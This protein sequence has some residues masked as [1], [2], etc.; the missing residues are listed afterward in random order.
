MKKKLLSLF[1][2]LLLASCRYENT[3]SVEITGRAAGTVSTTGGG[4]TFDPG[5]KNLLGAGTLDVTL[6]NTYTTAV[7][8]TN[9]LADPNATSPDSLTA[10]KAWRAE[11]VKLRLNPA[12]FTGDNSPSPALLAVSGENVLPLDG[13]VTAPNGGKTVEYMDVLS[14]AL[15]QQVAAAADPTA[16]RRVVFGVTLRGRTLDGAQLDSGEWFFPVDVCV[17]CLRPAVACVTGQDFVA[18]NCFGFGQDTTP[19]CV[20]VDS[21]KTAC[22]SACVDVKTDPSNCGSCGTVCTAGQTCAAGT[23]K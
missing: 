9:N 12:S 4:C 1:G 2:L 8:V 13:Q 3:S 18:S 20:C 16:V 22:G 11:S 19:V 6:Q 15:G 10:A 14:D 23:C 17:G 21:T 5:G 7:Y